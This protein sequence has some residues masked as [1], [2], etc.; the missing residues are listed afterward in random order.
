MDGLQQDLR[1]AL[2][3]LRNSWS[4]LQGRMCQTCLGAMKANIPIRLPHTPTHVWT[5]AL[6]WGL[7]C[8]QAN[9]ASAVNSV[10]LD[11]RFLTHERICQAGPST[12]PDADP[13]ADSAIHSATGWVPDYE[14]YWTAF[15]DQDLVT[16]RQTARTDPEARF[17]EAMT[18]LAAGKRESAECAFAAIGLQTGD[19]TVAFAAQLMLASTLWYEHKWTELRDFPLNSNRAADVRKITSDL[20]S[21][22]KAFAAAA[23]EVTTFPDKTVVLP[24]K[25]TPVGTP[26][27]SVR[28]NGKGYDF[29]LDTGSSMTVISSQVAAD[30]KIAA[31]S[32]DVL[33]VR[34]FAGS[35]PVKAASVQRL[36]IGPIVLTNSPALIMDASLMYVRASADG[37]Q[38]LGLKIDGIIGWDTLRQLDLTMNYA[39]RLIAIKQ[40]VQLGLSA[41]K[42][43]LAWF[44]RAYVEVKS[45]VAG[46]LHFTLDTGAQ[47]TL[48]NATV[49]EKLRIS[50]KK[51]DNRLFGIARRGRQTTRIVPFLSIEVGGKSLRLEDVIVYGPVISGM[52]NSDGILGSD[53][54]KFGTIR[55]DATN[56]VFTIGGPPGEDF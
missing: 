11:A 30:A 38:T 28:V 40:P 19:I 51:A 35:A 34:T 52:I 17:A 2:R 55:I 42:R 15:A 4:Y 3:T 24:L 14:T 31:L 29:W 16:L 5:L 22:G 41:E 43:N 25:V 21:W 10:V 27:V 36:D 9:S 12:R 32:S 48:L 50:T 26:V 23:D 13:I 8:G 20:Q 46:N 56:G 33:T 54:A 45:K 53:M 18:L 47:T 49:M 39:A 1:Y 6:A 44:G 7:L 37:V